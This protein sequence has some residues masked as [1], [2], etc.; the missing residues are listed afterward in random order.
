MPRSAAKA[1]TTMTAG[2]FNIAMNMSINLVSL[3]ASAFAPT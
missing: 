3:I 1:S 2:V